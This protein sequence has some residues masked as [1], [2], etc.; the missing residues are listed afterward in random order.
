MGLPRTRLSS[1]ASIIGLCSASWSLG[2]SSPRIGPSD[3]LRANGPGPR[4]VEP[5]TKLYF[6]LRLLYQGI[7]NWGICLFFIHI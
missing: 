2:H 1:A 3:S 5:H 7:L 6:F 4:I